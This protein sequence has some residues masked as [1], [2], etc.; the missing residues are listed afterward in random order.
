MKHN[1]TLQEI[2]QIKEDIKK[3]CSYWDYNP[4]IIELYG[5]LWINGFYKKIPYTNKERHYNKISE[6]LRIK[7]LNKYPFLCGLK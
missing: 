4:V 5:E 3:I 7:L 2:K 1:K 6:S